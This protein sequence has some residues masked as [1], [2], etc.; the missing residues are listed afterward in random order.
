MYIYDFDQ[1]CH[2]FLDTKTPKWVKLY[3]VAYELPNGHKMCQMAVI[4][5]KG[6]IICQPF[7]FQGTQKCTQIGIFGLKIYHL[8]T[9]M[10][11]KFNTMHSERQ[12]VDIGY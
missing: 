7:P 6:Q 2:I 8:G 11:T 1:G 4:Y 10:L 5:S 9:L 3:H 12:N